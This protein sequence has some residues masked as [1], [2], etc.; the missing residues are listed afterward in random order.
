MCR[1]GNNWNN[2]MKQSL[3]VLE[4]QSDDQELRQSSN[5]VTFKNA[6]SS[7]ILKDSLLRSII[8]GYNV[9]ETSWCAAKDFSATQANISQKKTPWL[10]HKMYY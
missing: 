9:L 6:P 3:D 5:H 4:C 1:K 10:R 7:R 8:G 2:K